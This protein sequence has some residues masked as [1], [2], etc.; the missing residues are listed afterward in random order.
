MIRSAQDPIN[1]GKLHHTFEVLH[2]QE[3]NRIFEKAKSGLVF[4]TF[5]LLGTESAPL[6]TIVPSDASHQGNLIQHPLY[7]K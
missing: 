6:I 5:Y 7:C 3:G 2:D 4:E 1:D